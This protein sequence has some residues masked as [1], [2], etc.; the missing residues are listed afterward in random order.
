M[1]KRKSTT[2]NHKDSLPG[3]DT[4][5]R[6][7]RD[8]KRDAP[9]PALDA[10]IL[11]AA[12]AAVEQPRFARRWVVPVSVAAL[13]VLSVSVV[14]QWVPR[15]V[16]E[17]YDAAPRLA[18]APAEKSAAPPA[19]AH[20]REAAA[21]AAAPEPKAVAPAPAAA[22]PAPTQLN[23]AAGAAADRSERDALASRPAA[24]AEKRAM[25]RSKTESLKKDEAAPA[26][27]LAPGIAL[28][29]FVRSVADVVSVS[30]EGQPGA[31]QFSV[32]VRSADVGCSQYA[33]WWEVIGTDGKLLHRQVLQHS[34]VDEQPFVRAGGP[35]AIA[36]GTVVWV[37]AHMNNGGYG[38]VAF[39]GSV[40][41]GFTKAVLAPDFAANLASQAPLPQGCER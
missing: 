23:Q 8:G 25:A 34:H 29:G 18:E 28:S 33:D 26:K 5:A 16:T 4:L 22:P 31:Y 38:G 7:Y 37:R 32:G 13:V 24:D 27:S 30:V 14:V 19:P 11:A 39:T 35:V 2:P 20:K 41:K 17:Q 1:A 6:I 3:E 12:Q 15:D 21:P 40:E 36:R 9:P 10:Q